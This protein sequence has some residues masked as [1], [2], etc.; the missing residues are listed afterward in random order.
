MEAVDTDGS[1][2]ATFGGQA[3]NTAATS[4]ATYYNGWMNGFMCTEAYEVEWG[5][6]LAAIRDWLQAEGF[7]SDPDHPAKGFYYTQNEPQNWPDYTI[8]AYLCKQA[9]NR[10]PGLKIM[11]SREAHPHIFNR[12]DSLSC[13]YDIWMAH[14]NRFPPAIT[15]DRQANYGEQSWV[16][17]LDSDASCR[18]PGECAKLLAPFVSAA[19]GCN[20]YDAIATNDGMHYRAIP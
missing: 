9:R 12:G 14:I 16:Y 10:A 20:C 3:C 5:K 8:S 19:K 17:F 1:R 18:V 2:P 4:W 15:W 7:Y 6:Y 13:G 11:L